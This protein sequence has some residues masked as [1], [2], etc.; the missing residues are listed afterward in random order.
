MERLP[1]VTADVA[2]AV[3]A[4]L[5]AS[6]GNEYAIG[7][8]ERLERENPELAQF[9]ALFAQTQEN[10]V[11]VATGA[12]LTYRLLESQLEADGMGKSFG[13]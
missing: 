13:V 3:R 12:V 7:I 2:A 4:E 8:L 1:G 10:A 11:G 6:K 5:V 9:I